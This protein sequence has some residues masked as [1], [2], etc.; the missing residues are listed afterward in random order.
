MSSSQLTRPKTWEVRYIK[1]DEINKNTAIIANSFGLQLGWAPAR[2]SEYCE[3][4]ETEL[5]EHKTG[6]AR[7]AY[8]AAQDETQMIGFAWMRESVDTIGQESARSSDTVDVEV[9]HVPSGH[10]RKSK[11]GYNQGVA[12]D[13]LE[14]LLMRASLSRKSTMRIKVSREGDE[15]SEI[16]AFLSSRCFSSGEAVE[17]SSS[18]VWWSRP[19][20]VDMPKLTEGDLW[21]CRTQG[22]RACSSIREKTLHMHY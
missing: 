12:T 11:Q 21:Q 5:K 20:F 4:W 2:T 6:F 13:L 18:Q 3:R 17:G 9:L 19:I 7:M 1:D 22:C 10:R 14:Q 16:R 8:I 15:H